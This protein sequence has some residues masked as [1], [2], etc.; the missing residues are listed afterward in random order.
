MS[1]PIIPGPNN[2]LVTQSLAIPPQYP[3]LASYAD[4][5]SYA[6]FAATSSYYI[7]S[8]SYIE[9][10]SYSLSS[11]YSKNALSASY[12]TSASYSNTSSYTVT[13]SYALNVFKYW[14]TWYS[15]KTQ[16]ASLENTA[17]P[18][19]VNTAGDTFSGFY[20]SGSNGSTVSGSAIVIPKTGVY[21][22]Q[23]SLQLQNIGGGGTNS[24]ASI[25]L[26]KNGVDIPWTNTSVSVYS[27]SPY[28]VAAWDFMGTYNSGD[29]L[30][31]IWSTNHSGNQISAV[32]ATPPAPATPSVIFTI[33]E[34]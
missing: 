34:I 15:T 28:I 30:E 25:W 23:F 4:T 20:I 2:E 17:Y 31:L 5:A 12:A 3:L 13:A 16:T 18:I 29:K 10:A 32:A 9:S 26:R 11:S 6:L 14:G 24:A 8:M 7:T 1:L 33:M 19:T 27:N 22:F 21:D